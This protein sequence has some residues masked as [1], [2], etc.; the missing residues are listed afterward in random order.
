[1]SEEIEWAAGDG[2]KIFGRL[3][4]PATSPLRP[5]VCLPGLTRNGRD[6][7]GIAAALAAGPRARRVLA[8]DFRG[9]GRS[10][11]ADPATYRPDVEGDDVIAGL[12]RLG[13]RTPAYLGTSRGGIVTMVLAA[14]NGDRVGPVILNDIGPVVSIEGL[15]AIRDRMAANISRPPQDWA[16]AVADLR[17]H[18]GPGF[19]ALTDEDWQRFARQIYRTDAGGLPVLDYDPGLLTAFAAFDPAVGYPPLWPLFEA[20]APRPV[21]TVRGETSD[22]L[23]GETL[24]GMVERLPDMQVHHVP[25]QGH[26]PLLDDAP[27]IEAITRFLDEADAAA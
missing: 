26:A 27:T 9:R 25:D 12:D 5:V 19:P 2:T 17:A 23:D 13:W 7:D 18:M 1:M 10:G 6:F 21:M 20:L 8:V 15:I 16:G 24:A 11:Y 3:R 14:R 4:G 22:L